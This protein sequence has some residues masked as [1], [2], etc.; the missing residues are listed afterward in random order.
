MPTHPKENKRTVRVFGLAS[1]LNDMGSDMIYPLW[2][3]FVTQ[4]L[5][6]DM[7]ILGLIDGIGDALVSIS[8]AFSGY[9]SDKLR[10]RKVFIWTGYLM[11]GLS[12][13]GYALSQSW[14]WL[15]PFRI[16]DRTGKIR[17]APRDAII[18]DVSD[19]SNR[20]KNFGFLRMM[21]NFGAVT[22]ILLTIFLL[23]YLSFRS[24]FFLAAIPSLLAVGLILFLVKDRPAKDFPAFKGIRLRD[25]PNNF[26]LLLISSFIFSIGTFSYSFLLIF[27]KQ[28][29][30]QT[31]L[32]PIFYLLFT[33]VAALTSYPFGLLSDRLGNKALLFTAFAFWGLT[34]L[35]VL[36]FSNTLGIILTFLLYGFFQGSFQTAQGAY[37]AELAPANI[38]GSLYG[39]YQMVIGLAALPASLGAGLIW[40]TY[41]KTVPFLVALVLTVVAAVVLL[42]VK[43]TQ[44]VTRNT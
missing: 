35:T 16:L 3:L 13:I 28:L 23:N 29:G 39:G 38:R 27:A 9:W 2:P 40:D 25:L 24:L 41:G 12:R 22:G 5:G 26:R 15:I 11:G 34:C 1:F 10:K 43:N 37:V 44:H 4:V 17:G 20:G 7:F 31:A 30:I 19:T 14:P 8:K 33:V 18:A 6:A 42:F 32:V 36:F 21:D